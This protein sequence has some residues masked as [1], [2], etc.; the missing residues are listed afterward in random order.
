MLRYIHVLVIVAVCAVTGLASAAVEDGVISVWNFDDGTADDVFGVN[1][2]ILH[3]DV[4]FAD[5]QIGLAVDL[6]GS[7]AYVEVPHT[8]SMDGMADAYSVAAWANI[9]TAGDAW[10]IV[11]KG[12]QLGGGPLFMFRL[13]TNNDTDLTWGGN[14]VMGSVDGIA[15]PDALMAEGWFHS[16]RVYE[17]GEWIHVAQI[18]DGQTMNAFLIGAPVPTTESYDGAEFQSTD[19][20]PMTAPYMLYPEE[21]IRIGMGYGWSD[22]DAR[23]LDA[24]IDEV[25][26]YDRALSLD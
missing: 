14:N 18:G 22:H 7:D 6:N 26:I 17:T 11:W 10:P 12:Y 25:V 1:D 5:G 3:G 16:A 19:P 4:Q 15:E 24:I 2:G 20:K 13:A 23:Y 21:P 9:R 8:A